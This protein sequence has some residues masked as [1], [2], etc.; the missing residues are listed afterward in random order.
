MHK[1]NLIAAA[2]FGGLAVALGA[3]G[4][5]GLE[6]ITKD[7]KILH[8]FQTG[9]QYQM[10]HAQALLVLAILYASNN[11]KW[12][13]WSGLCFITGII[14]FSGSLYLL[15][16]LNIEGSTAVKMVGPITPLGGVFFIAGWIFLL[17]AAIKKNK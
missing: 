10:Y 6:S 7:E 11:S 8:G 15:T 3:F 9:V 13:R 14:L 5:H 12:I 16:Y 17:V 4:A 1:N 2:I